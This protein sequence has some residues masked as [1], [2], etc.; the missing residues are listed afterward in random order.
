MSTL[1]FAQ[2]NWNMFDLS[3]SS[4]KDYQGYYMDFWGTDFGDVFVGDAEAHG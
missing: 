1:N 3:P 4:Y 2:V